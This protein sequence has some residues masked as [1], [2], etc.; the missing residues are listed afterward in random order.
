M[1]KRYYVPIGLKN[2]IYIIIQRLIRDRQY[3]K[4]I[5]DMYLGALRLTFRSC[6]L[7]MH[8]WSVLF[9]L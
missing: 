1:S 2:N 4:M 6:N 8:P 7:R 5:Y 9:W 3:N